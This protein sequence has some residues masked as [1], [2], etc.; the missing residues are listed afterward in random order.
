MAARRRQYSKD[1]V[2]VRFVLFFAMTGLV[3]LPIAATAQDVQLTLDK[4]EYVIGE[5]MQISYAASAELEYRRS[6]M[7]IYTV[8][9][10]EQPLIR[11]TGL[12]SDLFQWADDG[13]NTATVRAPS[14]AGTYEL[15]FFYDNEVRGSVQFT[16]IAGIPIPNG[17]VFPDGR[18]QFQPSEKV[19]LQVTLPGNRYYGWPGYSGAYLKFTARGMSDGAPL[20][21]FE[22]SHPSGYSTIH[23]RE[24]MLAAA[25]GTY[26]V[27]VPMPSEEGDYTLWLW[28]RWPGH[29]E[30]PYL[31]YSLDFSVVAGSGSEPTPRQ[32][33]YI[34][35][36]PDGEYDVIHRLPI[37][38]AFWIEALYGEVVNTDSLPATIE[39]PGGHADIAL[40]RVRANVFRAG[41][42]Y[43][44]P[45][46]PEPAAEP[47]APAGQ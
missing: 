20:G 24:E 12:A 14:Q 25:E 42:Y 45:P 18:T 38:Q 4:T 10:G 44:D 31:L 46:A 26:E 6:N 17:L 40:K 21:G 2:L 41:P 35:F 33:W 3:A 9:A 29:H 16:A 23:P 34:T 36:R 37:G 8:P 11:R 39:W 7:G 28:D 1:V 27:V 19:P 13:T 30:G 32:L 5:R 22:W 43:V 47:A 15:R